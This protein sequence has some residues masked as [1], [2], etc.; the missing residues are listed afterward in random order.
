MNRLLSSGAII[1]LVVMVVLIIGGGM[2]GCP[3]YNVWSAQ[4]YGEAEL[5]RAEQNR[6]IQI[7]QSRAKADAAKFEAEAEVARAQGVA[8]ANRIIGE[9]LKGEEGAAYLRYLWV[10]GLEQN[11]NQ[12]IVYVPTEANLPL[13]EAGRGQKP[14]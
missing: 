13:L 1:G 11:K 4:K 8:Q 12:T 3:I 9:S 10:N 2:Y 14:Q 5:A 6:Q 7:A